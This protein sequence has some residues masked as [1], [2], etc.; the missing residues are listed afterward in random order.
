MTSLPAACARSERV[1]SR[2]TSKVSGGVSVHCLS[3]G[4]SQPQ[5]R[6]R[7]PSSESKGR[8]CGVYFTILLMAGLKFIILFRDCVISWPQRSTTV[9]DTSAEKMSLVYEL[10]TLLY[11]VGA[12][13]WSL[14]QSRNINAFAKTIAKHKRNRETHKH[15][16][17]KVTHSRNSH[18]WGL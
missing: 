11:N 16:L 7:H 10:A 15:N 8:S 3:F 12:K 13:A 14:T 17:Q 5:S 1:S 4:V 18:H 2:Q 6:N 9:I